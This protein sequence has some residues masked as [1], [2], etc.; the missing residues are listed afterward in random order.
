MFDSFAFWLI[1]AWLAWCA[2]AALAR[3]SEVRSKW[4]FHILAIILLLIPASVFAGGVWIT[5]DEINQLPASGSAWNTV[6]SAATSSWGSPKLSD[7]NNKHGLKVLAGAYVAVRTNNSALAQQV[8][9]AV[10]TAKR[11][12]DDSS[13]WNTSNGVL[14]FGR[15]APA[16]IFAADLVGLPPGDDAE[17]RAWLRVMQTQKIGTH[18][19]WNTLRGCHE[20]DAANWAAFAGAARVAIAAYLNDQAELDRCADILRAL[21]GNRSAYPGGGYFN[22]SSGLHWSCGTEDSWTGINGPCSK[23]IDGTP[24]N[25]DGCPVIDTGDG[26]LRWPPPETSYPWECFQG[27]YVQAEILH[28]REYYPYEWSNQALRRGLDFMQRGGWNI[29]NPAKSVPWIANARYGTKFSTTT[30]NTDG[31]A[32]TWTEW[33]HATASVPPPPCVPEYGPWSEWS[34]CTDGIETRFRT[35]LNGCEPPITESRACTLPPP[36]DTTT[37]P[38][39]ADTSG[40]GDGEGFPWM[41]AAAAIASL[42]AALSAILVWMNKRKG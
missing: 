40:T 7:Q 41:L 32:V 22:P 23:V 6:H 13:E 42:I 18:G 19:R 30:N 9:D 16:Y 14:A 12:F 29:T 26:P 24:R 5:P 17:F 8:R 39:P 33:T 2:I 15:L 10:M 4:P 21:L 27:W 36:V 34:Q 1:V 31:R 37:P 20:D 25:L 35:D 11:T 38:P 28:R 3:W